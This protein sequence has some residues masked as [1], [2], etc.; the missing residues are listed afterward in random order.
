MEHLPHSLQFKGEAARTAGQIEIEDRNLF[1]LKRTEVFRNRGFSMWGM[2]TGS[3]EI[4][5][6]NLQDQRQ[7]EGICVYIMGS[8]SPTVFYSQMFLQHFY[9]REEKLQGAFS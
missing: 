1:I 4:F 6:F 9:M 3:L 8:L 5:L 2:I 7:T